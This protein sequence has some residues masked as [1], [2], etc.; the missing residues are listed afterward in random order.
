[1]EVKA[2]SARKRHE[3]IRHVARKI[4]LNPKC[5]EGLFEGKDFVPDHKR[6]MLKHVIVQIPKVLFR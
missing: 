4:R 5:L 3:Q 6:A 1:M 2:V